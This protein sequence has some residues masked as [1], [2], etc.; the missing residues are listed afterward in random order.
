MTPETLATLRAMGVTG[1]DEGY[2][3]IAQ[4]LQNLKNKVPDQGQLPTVNL[5]NSKLK[6][7]P[8]NTKF[9]LDFLISGKYQRA[10]G[11][12]FDIDLQADSDNVSFSTKKW[13]GVESG[14]TLSTH[15]TAKEAGTVNISFK[16]AGK[17]TNS[18][19]LGV[20]KSA[21][22]DT[23]KCFCKKNNWTAA[24]LKYIVTELRKRDDL[25][26]QAQYELNGNPIYVDSVGKLYYGLN[27]KDAEKQ[28]L[29]KKMIETSFY[30]RNDDFDNKPLKDRIFFHRSNSP[31]INNNLAKEH[32]NYEMLSK[33]LT[34]TFSKYAIKNCIQRTHFLAQIY[35]ETN[36]LRTTFEGAPK[37][38]YSGGDFY[39]GRGLKQI[40]HDYNYLE[41]YSTTKG[42]GQK[43]LF[44]VY[45][46]KRIEKHLNGRLVYGEPL[47]IM[48]DRTN[49]EFISI[50]EMNKFTEFVPLLSTSIYWACDSAGWYWN[51]VKMN[52]VATDTE[53]AIRVVSAKINR[54]EATNDPTATINDLPERKKYFES[55]KEILEYENCQ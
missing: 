35:V 30:D 31:D 20:G 41:Y 43:N 14:W 26:W 18:V 22:K 37:N 27:K 33:Y 8:Q 9:L 44:K 10:G 13:S 42:K 25:K 4:N 29:K 55:L 17:P 45:M 19:N 15:I 24:D 32:A 40:T 11:E 1:L 38:N 2:D 39:R 23:E 7:I 53:D 49:N 48:N 21:A 50:E 52:E 47:D 34:S 51:K 6:T 54:P 36:R 12:K 28:G 16:I 3:M 5:K 46:L